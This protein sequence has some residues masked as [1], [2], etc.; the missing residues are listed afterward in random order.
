M[1]AREFLERISR[2]AEGDGAL[3]GMTPRPLP[4]VLEVCRMYSWQNIGDPSSYKASAEAARIIVDTLNRLVLGGGFHGWVT[5]GA[6]EGNLLALYSAREAG[7]R[8]VVYPESAHYSIVKS[9][10][11]LGLEPVPI[12]VRDGYRPLI[13]VMESKVREGDIVV[14]T[15]GTT[16]TG[17]IDPL[18]EFS[19]IA[20]RR[21]AVVHVDAAFTGPIMRYLPTSKIPEELPENVVSI[22]MDLHKVVEAPIGVGTVFFRDRGMLEI[23]FNEAPYI[24]SGRQF[25]V[26][27]TRPGGVVVAGA[28]AL[29]LL[30]ES[31]LDRLASRLMDA[32]RRIVEELSGRGYRVP[33]EVETPILCL[34]HSNAGRIVEGI[35]ARGYNPYTCLG[36]RGIRMAVMPHTLE[37][38]DRVVELLSEA[39]G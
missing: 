29:L 31:G 22:V 10:R 33:H 23:L 39:A 9:A 30:L 26:L 14:A 34:T 4:S 35:R 12:P 15:I 6:S 37:M 18:A 11:I 24:P 5:S 25:G 21:G 17:Y 16:E 2:L 38:V 19:R 28:Y 36:G 8:R 3:G 20:A 27:G 7:F 32:A 1:R 13:E